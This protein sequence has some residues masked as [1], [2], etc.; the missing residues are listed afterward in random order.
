MKSINYV[1]KIVSGEW[2]NIAI[3]WRNLR[4]NDTASY[5][6]LRSDDEFVGGLEVS[7]DPNIFI[8]HSTIIRIN[9]SSML[10]IEVFIVIL[11][12]AISNEPLI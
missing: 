2:A 1:K 7:E 6:N 11:C 9:I 10:Q 3:R 12:T 4:Y 8:K 5:I